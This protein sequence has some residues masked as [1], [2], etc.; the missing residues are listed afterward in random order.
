MSAEAV[1]MV[2]LAISEQTWSGGEQEK[3]QNRR[4]TTRVC[5]SERGGQRDG[6]KD[7][8]KGTL[9]KYG[10]YFLQETNKVIIS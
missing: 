8:K 10:I 5:L 2:D 1:Q 7:K 4:K 3:N 6:Q 9:G